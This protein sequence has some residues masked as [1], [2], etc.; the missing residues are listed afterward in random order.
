MWLG[1]GLCSVATVIIGRPVNLLENELADTSAR[2]ETQ[3][4]GGE[5]GNFEDL[6]VVDPGVD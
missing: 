4:V 1:F 6:V 5:V 3:N 2:V